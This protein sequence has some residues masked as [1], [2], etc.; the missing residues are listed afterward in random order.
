MIGDS[1]GLV[2][3]V[4]GVCHQM[5]NRILYA[6]NYR[7]KFFN[8]AGVVWPPSFDIS[9][10]LYLNDGTMPTQA[11]WK[12]FLRLVNDVIKHLSVSKEKKVTKLLASTTKEFQKTEQDL[13]L[14]SLQSQIDQGYTEANSRQMILQS[15]LGK[16]TSIQMQAKKMSVKKPASEKL[17]LAPD[18]IPLHQKLLAEK[19]DLDLPLFEG[20]IS[21]EDYVKNLN[22]IVRNFLRQ[23]EK[24]MPAKDYAPLFGIKPGVDIPDIASVI[25]MPKLER[26]KEIGKQL[27]F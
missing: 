10:I 9:R 11:S 13:F 6:M 25:E 1:C 5:C 19:K 26:Y 15:T 20:K 18:L 21:K 22:N 27:K 23:A 12:I 2:Y 8:D 7:T 16:A 24:L 14:A 3:G 4:H 17:D